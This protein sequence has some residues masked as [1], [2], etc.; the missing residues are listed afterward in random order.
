MISDKKPEIVIGLAGPAGTDLPG[1]AQTIVEKL[2]P[3]GYRCQEIRVSQLIQEF[4]EHPLKQTISKA[5]HGEKVRLLMAAG[6]ILRKQADRGDALIPL[7]INSIR[8]GRAE[9]LTKDGVLSAETERSNE[10]H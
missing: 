9:I 2:C 10:S 6:D 7:V 4:C 5:K 3:F 8:L 1:L